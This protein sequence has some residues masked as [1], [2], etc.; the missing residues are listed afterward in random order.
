MKFG[1]CGNFPYPISLESLG[2]MSHSEKNQKRQE[3][4]IFLI[5]E[6]MWQDLGI[7][8]SH[9]ATL[10]RLLSDTRLRPKILM[11]FWSFLTAVH[12]YAR[13]FPRQLRLQAFF[14]IVGLGVKVVL[15]RLTY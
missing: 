4:A 13:R 12:I 2:G 8:A 6:R 15:R 10:S 11:T 1:E 3:E 7:S 9:R 14:F 5:R